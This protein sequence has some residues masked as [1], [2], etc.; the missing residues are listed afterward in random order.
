MLNVPEQPDTLQCNEQLNGKVRAEDVT[1]H[2]ARLFYGL[3]VYPYS[4]M[5][6]YGLDGYR[7]VKVAEPWGSE[8]CD[9]Q[10]RVHR[11]PGCKRHAQPHN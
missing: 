2:L 7:G 4:Q 3:P 9:Q 11:A 6:R 8:G 5:V 1:L 10:F